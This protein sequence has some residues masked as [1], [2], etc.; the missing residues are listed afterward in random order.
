MRRQITYIVQSVPE[1]M[2]LLVAM[3]PMKGPFFV[4][5]PVD[6]FGLVKQDN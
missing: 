4:G 5:H 2:D 6:P 3:A 1:K